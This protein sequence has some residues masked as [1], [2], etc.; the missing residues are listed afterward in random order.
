[1]LEK[2]NQQTWF[3]PLLAILSIVFLYRLYRTVTGAGKRAGDV[4]NKNLDAQ[5]LMNESTHYTTAQALQ[6]VDEL[7][8]IAKSASD[9][10][11]GFYWIFGQQFLGYG[12]NYVEDED[13]FVDALN[14]MNTAK[15]AVLCSSYYKV[16]NQTWTK[17]KGQ[18]IK[19]DFEKYLSKSEQ[20]RVK[21]IIKNNLK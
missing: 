17:S 10:I 3:K 20:N 21:S 14:Q 2:L 6:R 18:S 12:Y 15:E 8:E 16:Y 1:M 9:A 13:G 19:A 5:V 11:W 4:I 7:K